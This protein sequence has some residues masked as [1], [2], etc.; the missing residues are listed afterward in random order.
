MGA[1][2]NTKSKLGINFIQQANEYV[3]QE[4]Q[5][6]FEKFY[7]KAVNGEALQFEIPMIRKDGQVV[8]FENFLINTEN[9][10]QTTEKTNIIPSLMSKTKTFSKKIEKPW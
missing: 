8:W 1:Q 3:K 9:F 10:R 4:H 6:R 7:R 5:D 2:F